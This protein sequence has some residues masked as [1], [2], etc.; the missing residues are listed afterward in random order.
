MDKLNFLTAGIPLKTVPRTYKNAFNDLTEMGLNGIEIEFV[1][2]VNISASNIQEVQELAKPNE[3]VLTAHAPFF[4]NLNSQEQE[5]IDASIDRI[6]ETARMAKTLN[7]YSIVFHAAYYMGLSKEDT[8]HKVKEG[9]EKILK[10]VDDEDINVFIRPETTGKA[11]QWGDLEEVVRLSK[12]FDKVLPCVDFSHLYARTV[13]QNNTYDEFS[14]MFEFIG[15]ELGELALNNFHAH[16]AG[17]E[18]TAKGERKH[19]N[20][21]ESE[22][23]YKD[24]L[25]A[26]KKFDV[27]GVVVCE[28]PN[29]EEDAKILADYYKS[30]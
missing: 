27:K 22:F 16:I 30:L 29:I 18:F 9:F 21:L 23:N 26:F 3:M 15:N 24:L 28:S 2:G 25:K 8:Y 1:R 11:T 4:V 19:L 5:K 14:K 17:I 7:L 12:E 6:I 10:V 20:L 13:G